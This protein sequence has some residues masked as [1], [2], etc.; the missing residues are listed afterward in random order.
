M[1]DT[2]R[3][4]SG[5]VGACQDEHPLHVPRHRHAATDAKALDPKTKD[6]IALGISV[7]VRCDA[8]IAFHAV[9]AA[10]QGATRDEA[11]ETMGM[12]IYTGAGPS[13][14]YAAQAVEEYDQFRTKADAETIAPAV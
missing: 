10:R 2:K 7:A 8:R 4:R 13:V 3:A 14:I 12:A 5:S 6:L 9:S 1:I 11:M